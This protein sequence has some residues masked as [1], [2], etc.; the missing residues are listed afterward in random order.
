MT[1]R[2]K[3]TLTRMGIAK[4][5]LFLVDIALFPNDDV[6]RPY[7]G[8]FARATAQT[9]LLKEAAFWCPRSWRPEY[10]SDYES[11]EDEQEEVEWL[12]S[13]G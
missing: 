4:M 3:C 7:L 10:A 12:L 2:C 11:E 13:V 5:T 9:K 6:L 1:R 8:D